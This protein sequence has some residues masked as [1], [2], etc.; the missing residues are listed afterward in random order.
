ME[1][2]KRT[3]R[4]LPIVVQLNRSQDWT[5]QTITEPGHCAHNVIAGREQA[6]TAAVL[7]SHLFQESVV[8]REVDPKRMHPEAAILPE[9][10]QNLA[11]VAY[12]SIG[13]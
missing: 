12:L 11:L 7:S 6:R 3:I 5:P 2:R 10:F 4:R 1:V 13:N 8:D 9:M